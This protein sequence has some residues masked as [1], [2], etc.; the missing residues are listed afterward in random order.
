[1]ARESPTNVQSEPS[2][3]PHP[4]LFDVLESCRKKLAQLEKVIENLQETVA[5]QEE[6]ITYLRSTIGV[7]S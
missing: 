5:H 1:M 6:E 3:F 7:E 4:R 2:T